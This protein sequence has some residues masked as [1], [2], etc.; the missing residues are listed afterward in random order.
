MGLATSRAIV[1]GVVLLVGG[2]DLNNASA[3][4][5]AVISTDPS[6]PTAVADS[7]PGT[8]DT[9]IDE[10]HVTG[11]TVLVGSGPSETG[12]IR[13]DATPFPDWLSDRPEAG[14]VQ[15]LG[16]AATTARLVVNSEYEGHYEAGLLL[17]D[18]RLV[19]LPDPQLHVR[20]GTADQPSIMALGDRLGIIGYWNDL[21]SDRPELWLL[22]P[23]TLEWSR[24][25]ELVDGPMSWQIAVSTARIDDGIVV[26]LWD[27]WSQINDSPV[28]D[29]VASRI[30]RISDDLEVTPLDNPPDNVQP[31]FDVIAAHRAFLINSIFADDDGPPLNA[32]SIDLASGAWE[33]VPN[34][35][36]L[37]CTTDDTCDWSAFPEEDRALVPLANSLLVEVEADD[38]AILD[39]STLT[40][41]DVSDAPFSLRQH[42][43]FAATDDAVL[44]LPTDFAF[45]DEP[46]LAEVGVFDVGTGTW[47][48]FDIERDVASYRWSV[49]RTDKAVL[50]G[51]HTTTPTLVFDLIDRSFRDASDTERAIWLD[52]VTGWATNFRTDDLIEAFARRN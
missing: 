41:T 29:V 34:P 47:Q 7:Q 48:S 39:A 50:L 27:F 33:P 49:V 42:H 14:R 24:G 25:P 21:R 2:C 26:T 43:V 22:D 30:L 3:P 52:Q 9:V 6:R 28:D 19:A 4:D 37:P 36:W 46:V 40:W 23:A 18:D 38:L 31:R 44:A 10:P 5:T 12:R 13:A 20:S 45:D 8:T 1:F 17:E 35:P 51:D 15:I 16:G 32:W 11:T